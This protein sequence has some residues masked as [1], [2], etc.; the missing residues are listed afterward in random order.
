MLENLKK[1]WRWYSVQMAGL[2]VIL[3]MIWDEL[4]PEVHQM[5]PPDKY[6]Y[7]QAFIAVCI[8]VGRV[9]P[10]DDV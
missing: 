5:I 10:Q 3:P 2:L 8:V 1:C 6:V 9:I 4:P 7:L